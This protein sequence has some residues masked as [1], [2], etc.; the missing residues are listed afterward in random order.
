MA[1]NV[2][3]IFGKTIQNSWVTLTTADTS[4]T[5]PGTNG[6]TLLTANAT[7]GSYLFRIFVKP[8]GTN[9]A[10]VLRIFLNNGSTVATASNNALIKELTLPASTASAVAALV[11]YELTLNLK[12]APGYKVIVAIGTSVAAG[13]AIATEHMDYS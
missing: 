12:L 3:P 2:N 9:V 8:L 6:A 5:A 1:A 7:D 13:Y 10:T 11:D 4:T